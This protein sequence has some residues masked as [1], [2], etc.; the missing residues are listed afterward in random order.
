MGNFLVGKFS[1]SPSVSIGDSN[2]WIIGVFNATSRH[3]S[4]QFQITDILPPG[5][6]YQSSTPPAGWTVSVVPPM[7][8]QVV[9]WTA[10]EGYVLAQDQLVQI[11]ITTGVSPSAIPVG[12]SSIMAVNLVMVHDA[13]HQ[14]FASAEVTVSRPAARVKSRDPF[15]STCS[16]RCQSRW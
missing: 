2:T 14:A 9:T 16:R 13:V 6:V 11:T 12:Q 8:Q 5:F 4:G 3:S 7:G 15:T 1:Q 10:P